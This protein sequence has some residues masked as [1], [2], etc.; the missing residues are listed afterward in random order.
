MT[1]IQAITFDIKKLYKLYEEHGNKSHQ[2]EF[3]SDLEPFLGFSN[4]DQIHGFSFGECPNL[5]TYIEVLWYGKYLPLGYFPDVKLLK[6][7]KQTI[8]KKNISITQWNIPKEFAILNKEY[9]IEQML[10]DFETQDILKRIK[11]TYERSHHK[12]VRNWAKGDY[13]AN[14]S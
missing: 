10:R 9:N 7:V 6:I 5:R 11:L 8:K 2:I 4:T 3:W 1:T 13:N 14:P 12:F